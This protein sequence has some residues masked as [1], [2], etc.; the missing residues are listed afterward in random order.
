LRA[1]ILIINE[2][3]KMKKL[4]FIAGVSAVIASPAF[5]ASVTYNGAAKSGTAA[6]AA[7]SIVVNSA[8]GTTSQYYVDPASGTASN[9]NAAAVQLTKTSDWSFDF[10]DP[11]HVTFTGSIAYGN[12]TTQ[13]NVTGIAS[14]DGRQSYYGVTQSFSGVG[15]FNQ[16]TNTFTYTLAASTSDIGGGSA[17]THTAEPV[18]KDG[19]TFFGNGICNNFSTFQEALDWEGLALNFVFSPDRSSFSG[20]LVGTNK[21]G[22]GIYASTATI[23][24][25]VSGTAATPAVPVPAAAWLFGSGLL[26]LAGAS[27]RRTK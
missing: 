2:E 17:E 13:T 23:N 26:G 27:R 15:S 10:T 25:Q 11:A 4:A 21:S 6:N 14:V 24:W 20:S 18:C 7:A 9:K 3:T 22:S 5:A 1:N 8:S 16:A 19:A 12:Y